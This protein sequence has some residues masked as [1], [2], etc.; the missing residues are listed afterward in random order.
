MRFELLRFEFLQ[1]L[2]PMSGP[3]RAAAHQPLRVRKSPH[4][5]PAHSWGCGLF[6]R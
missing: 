2:R 6:V 4:R 3:V 1:A 5:A